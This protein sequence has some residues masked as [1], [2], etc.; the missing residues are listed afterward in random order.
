MRLDRNYRAQPK[1]A[2]ERFEKA[3]KLSPLDPFS[4]NTQMG[5]AKADDAGQTAP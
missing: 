1:H 3:L 2:L 4:F 5:M